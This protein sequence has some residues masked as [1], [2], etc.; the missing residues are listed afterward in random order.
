MDALDGTDMLARYQAYEVA[1]RNGWMRWMRFATTRGAT[2][3]V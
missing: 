2:R 3:W 1:I